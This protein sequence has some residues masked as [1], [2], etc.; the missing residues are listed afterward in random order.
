MKTAILIL[1]LFT[2]AAC[3]GDDPTP[4]GQSCSAN[5]ECASYLCLRTFDN[6][7]EVAGGTCTSECEW[8]EDFTDS[9]P[10]GQVCLRYNA[11]DEYYC[12]DECAESSDC[13]E[14]DGWYCQFVGLDTSACIP[15]L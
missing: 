6:G 7:V 10:D 3:G 5:N 13:R 15:P 2:L 11:T 4:D 9:C 12:F 14:D 1:A 8:Y